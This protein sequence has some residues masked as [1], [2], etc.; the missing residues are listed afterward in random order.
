MQD[1]TAVLIFEDNKVSREMLYS[2]FEAI[3]D[4]FAPMPELSSKNV[5]AVFV[6]LTGQLLVKSAVFFY[7]SFDEEGFADK[8][9][10]IP[11]QQL[12][13]NSSKGPDLGAG[14]IR[15]ACRSQC[16]IEWHQQKLWDPEMDAAG[17]H[18]GGIKASIK[19]NRMGFIEDE[20]PPQPEDSVSPSVSV[21]NSGHSQALSQLQKR[22]DEIQ[23]ENK[24]RLSS[25]SEK[26]EAHSQSL[27]NKFQAHIH[28]A[29]CT[30]EEM[31]TQLQVELTKNHELK[32][33]I[34]GQATKIEGLREYFEHKLA[35]AQN[36]GE[37]ELNDLRKGYETDLEVQ[38]SA[39]TA[40]LKEQLKIKE[41]ELMY[42]ETQ[43]ENLLEE[44][45]K[46][47]IEKNELLANSGNQLLEKL[48]E[49]DI[50]FVSYQP[51]AGHMAISVDE[52]PEFLADRHQFVADKCGVSKRLYLEWL[53][54]YGNPVCH[55]FVEGAVHCGKP[56]PRV[57]NPSDW[58]IGETDR[59]ELHKS[60]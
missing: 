6:Q 50:N 33:I 42:R 57:E 60:H 36:T 41:V 51:G 16:C 24:L 29:R 3:L 46:A 17:I 52:I 1:L 21:Q 39:A 44:I 35:K 10:N 48:S 26:H 14:A 23:R 20:V 37:G 32:E 25:Q 15:L 22:C 43:Q 45:K 27:K 19:A 47:Q 38:V 53:E 55:S 30:L 31:Q 8:R 28:K 2:E 49:N 59:C 40:E 54:S 11:L 9:W 7:I 56:V 12:A 5:E 58:L 18:F 13:E 34:D 4:G